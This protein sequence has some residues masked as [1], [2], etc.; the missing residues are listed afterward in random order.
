MSVPVGR[1]VNSPKAFYGRKL[2]KRGETSVASHGFAKCPLIHG[3]AIRKSLLRPG[4]LFFEESQFLQR[5]D[6]PFPAWEMMPLFSGWHTWSPAL[7]Y[8]N[9]CA[10]SSLPLVAKSAQDRA[11]NLESNCAL[12]MADAW[13]SPHGSPTSQGA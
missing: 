2:K 11:E 12:K 7:G 3:S 4:D 8:G 9:F 13:H 6:L 1:I 5:K 10:P